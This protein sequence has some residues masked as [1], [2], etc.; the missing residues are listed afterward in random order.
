MGWKVVVRMMDKVP[1]RFAPK[2]VL[3]GIRQVK[4]EVWWMKH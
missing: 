2:A 3:E 4:Q 1:G